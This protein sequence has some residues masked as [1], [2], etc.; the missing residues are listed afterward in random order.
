MNSLKSLAESDNR[1]I[2]LTTHTPEIVKMVDKED[3][4]F[5]Q[6]GEE[7]TISAQQG[8]NIEITKVR[9]TLGILPFVYYKGVIFVGGTTDIKFLKNLSSI[10]SFKSIIDIKPFTFVPLHGG[11]NVDIWIKED[12]LRTSNVKCLYFKDRDDNICYM[13]QA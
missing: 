9:D 4:I 5:I 3:L 11:D 10:D 2:I 7:H 1:Q 13:Q 12:Y 8:N 6:K